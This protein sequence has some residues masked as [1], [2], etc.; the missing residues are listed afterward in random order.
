M[1]IKFPLSLMSSGVKL[2]TLSSLVLGQDEQESGNDQ[3]YTGSGD[4]DTIQFSITSSLTFTII[5]CSGMDISVGGPAQNIINKYYSS[6]IA[7]LE[8]YILHSTCTI[9]SALN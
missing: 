2:R 7:I 4:A 1:Q 8:Q 6:L 5:V 3:L 9:I